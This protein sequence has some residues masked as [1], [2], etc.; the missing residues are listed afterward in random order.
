MQLWTHHPSDFP[1]DD[2]DLVVDYTKGKYADSSME[3]NNG[4]RYRT[5]LPELHKRVETSQFLWCCTERGSYPRVTEDVD[6]NLMEW[7]LNVPLTQILAFHRISAWEDLVWSR[8]DD[9][10]ELLIEVGEIEP[11]ANDL[12]DLGVLVRVP[13]NPTWTT[14]HG[15]LP[16]K[17]PS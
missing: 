3:G 12:S 10:E 5:V 14:C 17:Y 16:P 8:S 13:L 1:V 11:P 2:P 4:F 15:P 9:W 7:E 6:K